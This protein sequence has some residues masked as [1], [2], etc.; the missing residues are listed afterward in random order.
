MIPVSQQIFKERNGRE[1]IG[2]TDGQRYRDAGAAL[3]FLADFR[4]QPGKINRID[5]ESGIS[6]TPASS[7]AGNQ[8]G[9]IMAGKCS[10]TGE[11]PESAGTA[12]LRR[13]DAGGAEQENGC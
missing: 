12:D 3:D 1:D 11:D 13:A 2:H 7:G 8:G 5:A 9:I 6:K 4:R 10:G